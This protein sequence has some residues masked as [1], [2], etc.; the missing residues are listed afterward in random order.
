MASQN[1]TYISP[2]RAWT[3]QELFQMFCIIKD[4]SNEEL[5]RASQT[6][7]HS[8]TVKFI[9]L[10]HKCLP[11]LHTLTIE[12]A[13]EIKNVFNAHYKETADVHSTQ[14]VNVYIYY[15]DK[16][17]KSLCRRKQW[18]KQWE[19]RNQFRTNW[20]WS[21]CNHNSSDKN[22]CNK[23]KKAFCSTKING[24][25]TDSASDCASN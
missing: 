10:L 25:W 5:I 11:S 13:R 14:Y 24:H 18:I 15:I 9:N 23:K 21:T 22:S 12:R 20:N 16:W 6:H 8:D 1:I 3:V 7:A 4:S 19:R 2:S 17:P